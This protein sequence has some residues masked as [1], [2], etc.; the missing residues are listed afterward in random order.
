MKF[1]LIKNTL[2]HQLTT[3]KA[4]KEIRSADLIIIDPH[5]DLKILDFASTS[6]IIHKRE[7]KITVTK[8]LKGQILPNI[9]VQ[10]TEEI[11]STVK[12]E[13]KYIHYFKKM[14]YETIIIP[15]IS[16]INGIT[17]KNHF[18]LTIRGR[19]ESFW[20]YD[21]KSSPS[22]N[23]LPIQQ[24][25]AVANGNATIVITNPNKQLR[26]ALIII[27]QH[28]CAS[29]SALV[30]TKDNTIVSTNLKDLTDPILKRL[31]KRSYMVVIN[32]NSINNDLAIHR[33]VAE[34]TNA[35]RSLL[36]V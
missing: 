5:T 2:N 13:L 16:S 35:L 8:L 27:A 34:S 28:R 29:T 23:P 26:T 24:I 12:D 31:H 19:N 30:C 6:A 21:C 17:G 1:I 36:A 25:A 15:G 11:S 33:N 18:P 3:I 4:I 22:S 7:K 10:L 9:V 20:V 32:P 14:R